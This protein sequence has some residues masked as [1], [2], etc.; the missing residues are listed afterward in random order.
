M[1]LLT[2]NYMQYWNK[3]LNIE[4]NKMKIEAIYNMA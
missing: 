4:K 3:L 2:N 1:H